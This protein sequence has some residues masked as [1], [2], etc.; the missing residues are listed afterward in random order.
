MVKHRKI[1]P[2]Y[3]SNIEYVTDVSSKGEPYAENAYKHI[4]YIYW[5]QFITLILLI[6]VIFY[7]YLKGVPVKVR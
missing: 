6:F 5:M 4:K 1:P 3:N 7:A 2:M